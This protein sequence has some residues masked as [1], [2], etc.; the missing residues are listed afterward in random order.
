MEP[1]NRQLFIVMVWAFLP[2]ETLYLGEHPVIADG[3]YEAMQPAIDELVALTNIGQLE[4]LI[5]PETEFFATIKT[6]YR[7]RYYF[8]ND[9]GE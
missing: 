3:Q 2:D 8:A 1:A 7:G 4:D 5:P 9:T 6:Q